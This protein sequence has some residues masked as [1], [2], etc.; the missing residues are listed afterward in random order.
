MSPIIMWVVFQFD[1][2]YLVTHTLI[3]SHFGVFVMNKMDDDI[4]GGAHYVY[5]TTHWE[6]YLLCMN[7]CVQK[8]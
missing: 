1:A 3:R 6:L 7:V 4:H 8:M 5:R 2:Q